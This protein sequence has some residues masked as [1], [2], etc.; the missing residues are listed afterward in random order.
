MK[1]RICNCW[2]IGIVL[3]L[4]SCKNGSEYEAA[5]PK[6]AALVVSANLPSIAEKGGWTAGSGQAVAQRISDALG[7][8]MESG[9]QLIDK[10]VKDP[11]K[12]GIDLRKD[13]YLFVGPQLVSDGLLARVADKGKVDD[14]LHTLHRQQ[15]CTEP[16]KGNGYTWSAMGRLLVAYTSDALLVL[17]DPKGGDAEGLL[18]TAMKLLGQNKE[19]GYCATPDFERIKNARGDIVALGS[20]GLVPRQYVAPMMMGISGDLKLENVKMLAEIHFGQGKMAIDFTDLTTDRA[21]QQIREKQAEASGAIEG[22]YLDVFPYNTGLWMT[23]HINGEKLYKILCENPTFS[24]QVDNS[25]MPI[26]FEAIFNAIKGDV[27]MAG[28][29][30]SGKFIAYADV[31]NDRFL[32]TFENLKP[33]LALTGGRIKLT[34]QG[35]TGY[36][37]RVTDGRLVGMGRGLQTWWFGVSNGRLYVTN[38][39]DWPGARVLGKS[40]RDRPWGK[41]VEGKRFYLS[42]NLG[43]IGQ[44]T[45]THAEAIPMQAFMQGLDY[46]TFEMK[47]RG[48]SRLELY[49]KNPDKNVLQPLLDMLR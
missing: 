24:N 3:I 7:S 12:S 5:L 30:T 17:H 2:W 42:L 27:A 43:G 45:G 28:D 4:A 25:M 41:Q 40:L 47:D 14:L 11:S 10:I 29:I 6:D 19:E 31:T 46:L 49:T 39:P 16:V 22:K 15:I 9:R 35:A 44:T 18:R 36:E 1:S 26:D 23:A 38:Q 8:G 37:L 32:Q 21:M 13:V 48:C 33:L 34:N 20:L